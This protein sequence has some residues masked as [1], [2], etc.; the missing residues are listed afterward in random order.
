MSRN[1]LNARG[2]HHGIIHRYFEIVNMYPRITDGEFAAKIERFTMTAPP[3]QLLRMQRIVIAEGAG[4]MAEE[5]R[6]R[7]ILERLDGIEIGMAIGDEYRTTVCLADCRFAVEMGIRDRSVPVLSVASREDYV[8]ALLRRKDL[9]WMVLKG[10]LAATHKVKLARWGLAVME[11]LKDDRLFEDLI[12]HQS[13]AEAK[14]MEA[15]G[16]MS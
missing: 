4:F 16:Q 1:R 9:L 8:D 2:P 14:I 11:H 12:A 13:S 6:W 7:D 3:E 15:I 10:K 5:P